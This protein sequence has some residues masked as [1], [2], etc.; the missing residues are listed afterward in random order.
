MRVQ[1]LYHRCLDLR[2]HPI[3]VMQAKTTANK[4][5]HLL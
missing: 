1:I 5:S 3:R 4:T 2:H